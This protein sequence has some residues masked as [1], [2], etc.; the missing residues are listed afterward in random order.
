M[1]VS[2]LPIFLFESYY[3]VNIDYRITNSLIMPTPTSDLSWCQLLIGLLLS[4]NSVPWL[5]V[6]CIVMEIAGISLI[7]E[8]KWALLI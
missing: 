4:I 5:A 7:L 3:Q 1:F 2:S 8:S 6:A